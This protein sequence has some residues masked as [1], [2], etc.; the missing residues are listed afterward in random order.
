[1]E[2]KKQ[3]G[4]LP[5]IF[6]LLSALLIVLALVLGMRALNTW[7]DYEYEVQWTPEPTKGVP[8]IAVT[9]DPNL[10]TATP[11][12]TPLL[13]S[14]GSEGD[15]V[16]ELQEIL[17]RLGY[18]EGAV[19]G[20]FGA[21]T[22]EA[23]RLFQ[24]QHGLAADGIVG[25][26]TWDMMHSDAAHQVVVTPTPEAMDALGSTVP[27]LV[28]RDHPIPD[29]FYPADLVAIGD[30]APEG[31]L[32]YKKQNLQG[33]RDAVSALIDMVEDATNQ[34]I[35]PWQISEAYRTYD[36][37]KAIFDSYVS[38]FMDDGFSRSNA[39]SATRQT[40]ADPGQSEHHTGLAFDITVPGEFFSDTAQYAWLALNCW[41]YGFIMRYTDEKQDITGFLGEEWHIRYVGIEHS[42]KMQRMDLCLEEYL[43]YLGR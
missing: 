41:D 10:V 1:M 12:P 34:G 18:Y 15:S 39:V 33:V 14:S 20:Q 24:L 27:M 31:L 17:Q 23:V 26:M 40:V 16:R 35:Y 29:G 22:K 30:Y 28:N 37:Q 8:S 19:D 5:L 3:K 2:K 38:D 11:A 36:D 13:F 7:S 42:K 21:G 9:Q 4:G 25:K 6:L 43:E 32:L